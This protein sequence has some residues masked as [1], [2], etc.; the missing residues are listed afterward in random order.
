MV[1][2]MQFQ[3]FQSYFFDGKKFL[4]VEISTGQ[5]TGHWTGQNDRT[6]A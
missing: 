6:R 4:V 2:M 1:Q 3:F 5:I